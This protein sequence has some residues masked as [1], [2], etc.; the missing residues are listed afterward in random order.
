MRIFCP[1][2]ICLELKT[3]AANFSLVVSEEHKQKKKIRRKSEC[4]N[5]LWGTAAAKSRAQACSLAKK[6]LE[7]HL[8]SPEEPTVFSRHLK[9]NL[10]IW[11]WTHITRPEKHDVT[12]PCMWAESTVYQGNYKCWYPGSVLAF[13]HKK[14]KKERDNQKERLSLKLPSIQSIPVNKK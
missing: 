7:M 5:E 1:K 3:H 2:Y 13:L 6:S 12:K 4:V 9:K 14:M 11:I 8:H 10:V